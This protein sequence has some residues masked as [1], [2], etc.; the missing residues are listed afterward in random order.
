MEE[1]KES[2]FKPAVLSAEA[3]EQKEEKKEPALGVDQLAQ[4]LDGLQLEEQTVEENKSS[5]SFDQK[6]NEKVFD[7][8]FK[9][10]KEQQIKYSN[11]IR[12]YCHLLSNRLVILLI[13]LHEKMI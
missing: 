13:S 12:D 4:K 1:E 10:S 11:P 3:T 8:L 9:T 5:K 2:S 6:L 7:M